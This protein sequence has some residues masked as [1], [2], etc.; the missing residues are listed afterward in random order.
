MSRITS[1]NPRT[2]SAKAA[3]IRICWCMRVTCLKRA[4]PCCSAFLFGF[5][6]SVIL[7]MFAGM[8]KLS[9]G[10]LTGGG[11]PLLSF[12]WSFLGGLRPLPG[13]A[14]PLLSFLG[15]LLPLSPIG[16]PRLSLGGLL[17]LLS[18]RLSFLGGLLPLAGGAAPWKLSPLGELTGGATGGGPGGGAT[19]R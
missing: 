6:A 10:E 11:K 17:P 5:T 15:G 7:S 1:G 2:R 14:P 18:P 9:L 12:L 8:W 3:S 4:L 19:P 16:G 13:G